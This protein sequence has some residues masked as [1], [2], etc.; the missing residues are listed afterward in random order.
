MQSEAASSGHTSHP[1][2]AT[3]TSHSAA[4][5]RTSRLLSRESASLM[6]AAT[7]PNA[8]EDGKVLTYTAEVQQFSETMNCIL[9]P[10][11]TQSSQLDSMLL[12]KLPRELRDKIYSDGVVEDKEIPIGVTCYETEDGEKRRRVQIEHPLMRACKQTRE[13]VAD[14]YYLENTFRVTDDLLEKRAITKL[15][16]LLTPWTERIAKLGVSHTFVRGTSES[17]KINFSVS[18]SQGRIV[19]EPEPSSSQ[20]PTFAYDLGAAF[21]DRVTVTSD[22]ICFCKMGKLALENDDCDLLSW[23]QEYA[24]LVQQPESRATYNDLLNLVLHCWTCAGRN[25]I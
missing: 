20:Y 8:G 14:I 15:R 24:G 1:T 4:T 22:N 11:T 18:T 23:M 17:A 21:A 9:H 13:E 6:D 10:A 7:A 16:G 3:S 5:P 19:V 12:S 2:M 25:V